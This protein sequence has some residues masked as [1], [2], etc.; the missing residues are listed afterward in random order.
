MDHARMGF[1]NVSL[2]VFFVIVVSSQTGSIFFSDKKGDVKECKLIRL[3][4]NHKNGNDKNFMKNSFHRGYY[5]K[6]SH[7]FSIK[8]SP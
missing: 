3:G 5:R 1:D 8:T 2:L 6:D 7:Y 4:A